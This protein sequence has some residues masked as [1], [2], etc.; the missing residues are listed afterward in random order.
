M[1]KDKLLHMTE[2]AFFVAALVFFLAAWIHYLRLDGIRLKGLFGAKENKKKQ[3]SHTR[4]IVDFADE[5]IISFAE[6]DDE[7]RI[8]CRLLGNLLCAGIYLVI[9]V[10]AVIF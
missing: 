3:K 1:N 2:S 9:S 6:L 10:V 5:K 4:D 7:E 8:V